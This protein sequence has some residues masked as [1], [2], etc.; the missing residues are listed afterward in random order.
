M[1]TNY[2]L[3]ALTKPTTL[4]QLDKAKKQKQLAFHPDKHPGEEEEYTARFKTIGPAY[5]RIKAAIQQKDA[6]TAPRAPPKPQQPKEGPKEPENIDEWFK[7]KVK[8]PTKYTMTPEGDLQ[9]PSGK[10][11]E[12]NPQVSAS[13]EY[14][15]SKFDARNQKRK[16]AEEA[17][18]I[19]K[20]ELFE[21]IQSYRSSAKT[22]TDAS[23]VMIANQKVHDAECILN[24]IAKEPREI[25]LLEGLRNNQLYSEDSYNTAK[26]AEPV[27][28]GTYTTFHWNNF[29]MDKP[30]EPIP[31]EAPEEEEDEGQQGGEQP[32]TK[33]EKTPE[34]KARIW[35]II[36]AKKAKAASFK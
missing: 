4:R 35:A 16:E 1:N 3:F 25:D 6:P 22:N 28:A 15:K 10:V 7:Q 17:Y 33:K 34:E 23:I 20:R 8:Y 9:T 19:A 12:L 5:N 2:E 26:I 18:V 11:F 14:I 21:I 27:I 36:R 32:K 13:A 24:S 31:D 29:F 30:Q